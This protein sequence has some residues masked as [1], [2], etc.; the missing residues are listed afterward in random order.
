MGEKWIAVVMEAVE[1]DFF[2]MKK[3]QDKEQAQKAKSNPTEWIPSSIA[4]QNRKQTPP[5]KWQTRG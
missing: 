2:T 3:A 4:K 1:A 5:E